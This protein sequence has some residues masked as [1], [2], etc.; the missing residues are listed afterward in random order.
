MCVALNLIYDIE[1]YI[2]VCYTAIRTKMGYNP[3]LRAFD[4]WR[5]LEDRESF[6]F[7]CVSTGQLPVF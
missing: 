2:V 4:S 7:G 3:N 6:L 5:L 1:F